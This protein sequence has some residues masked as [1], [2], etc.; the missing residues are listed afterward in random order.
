MPPLP[1][2]PR[3]WW[4][5][6]ADYPQCHKSPQSSNDSRWRR[7]EPV[8]R[9]PDGRRVENRFGFLD[10]SGSRH[11]PHHV[12]CFRS[13]H[14]LHSPVTKG[15]RKT[16]GS[17]R[18]QIFNKNKH[19]RR[20]RVFIYSARLLEALIQ[21]HFYMTNAKL[22]IKRT[23]GCIIP[24]L[25]GQKGLGQLPPPPTWIDATAKY[26]CRNLVRT[27]NLLIC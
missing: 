3:L 19:S 26:Q 20:K 4:C 16:A 15:T 23:I 24:K 8:H 1:E 9:S 17:R 11:Q 7:P 14:P 5:A 22:V 13:S 12:R 2:M 27:E 6:M 25:L 10:V 21:L 18:V